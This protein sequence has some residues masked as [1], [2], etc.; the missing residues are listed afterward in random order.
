[1]KQTRLMAVVTAT[2]LAGFAQASGFG[3]YEASARGNAMGGALT[4]RTGDASAVYYNPANM[5][6]NPGLQ[7]MAGITLINPHAEFSVGPSAVN[8]P[9]GAKLEEDWFTPP[10]VYATWQINDRIWVGFGEY[11]EYGLGIKYSDP[12]W[13]GAYNA[14]STQLETFTLNPSIAVKI[15]DR[16]SIGG[17]FRAIYADF[18][19]K[20]QLG[21]PNAM[22]LGQMDIA[23]DGWGYGYNLGLNYA[24]TDTIDFGLTYRSQMKL[25]L[26]GEANRDSH[27]VKVPTG[28]PGISIPIADHTS[29][30]GEAEITL[31]SS[32]TAGLNWQVTPKWS[33]GGVVT[34]TEW[35]TFDALNIYFDRPTVQSSSNPYGKVES[36]T[37][38]LAAKNWND[39][40]RFGFGTEYRFNENWAIQG[41]YVYDMA[42]QDKQYCDFMIP[43]GDRHML[44]IGGTYTT[45]AWSISLSYNYMIL[46]QGSGYVDMAPNAAGTIST[47]ARSA[48]VEMS[49]SYSHFI[50]C[51]VGYKF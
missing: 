44:G 23:A 3:L 14:M 48:K 7:F 41:G 46:T 50:G 42:P 35:S 51:S 1:M 25:K 47:Q 19:H 18:Q 5:T 10:H 49:D 11:S 21:I 34:W 8:S 45:G 4:G 40:Y 9:G 15:T 20:R 30:P 17:G 32:I 28:Y 6:Q 29:S 36:G 26:N 37:E 33:V 39:V 13:V 43:P 27:N 38:S 16:L 12:H 22:P 31:P 2:L 24:I